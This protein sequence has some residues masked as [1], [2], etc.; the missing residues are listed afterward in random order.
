MRLFLPI[1]ALATIANAQ[2]Q[3]QMI[4][5]GP[6]PAE[7]V[8]LVLNRWSGDDCSGTGFMRVPLPADGKLTLPA[9]RGARCWE[10]DPLAGL[11]A[12]ARDRA[13]AYLR[14]SEFQGEEPVRFEMRPRRIVDVVV[15]PASARMAELARDDLAHTDWIWNHN[16]AGLTIRA[17]FLKPDVKVSTASC[18]SVFEKGNNF[19]AGVINLYYGARG[20]NISCGENSAVFVHEVPVLGDAAHELSHR[21]GLN[22]LD[23]HR[24]PRFDDGHTTNQRGFACNNVMWTLSETLVNQL[25]PGQAFWMGLSCGS[26]AAHHGAC[27]SCAEE[28]GAASPC[29]SFS[30]GQQLELAVCGACI[31]PEIEKLIGA[32]VD[33][34]GRNR[35]C[36]RETLRSRLRARYQQLRNNNGLKLG[37]RSERRFVNRWMAEIQTVLMVESVAQLKDQQRTDGIGYLRKVAEDRALS[38]EKRHYLEYSALKLEN[39]PDYLPRCEQAQAAAK[40]RP[41][42]TPPASA[43]AAAPVPPKPA[44]APLP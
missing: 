26:F 13:V 25:S 35:L 28:E 33:T 10:D 17:R 18:G 8:T 41:H 32:N 12:M 38:P 2:L 19:V 24:D 22:Q 23:N 3:T 15:H 30:V 20:Q 9:D 4:V 29:P 34:Q 27:L 39:I 14:A 7:P 40:S 21:L 5:T 37:S 1:F 44:G 42:K 16:L 43:P 11:A 31:V 6:A 36:D